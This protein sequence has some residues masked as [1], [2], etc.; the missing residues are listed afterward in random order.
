MVVPLG[1]PDGFARI[2]LFSEVS[3]RLRGRR[4][5]ALVWLAISGVV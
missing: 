5:S 3:V 2:V 4:S 1:W